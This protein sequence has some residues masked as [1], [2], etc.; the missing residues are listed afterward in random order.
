VTQ[1]S[2]HPPNCELASVAL[3]KAR[4]VHLRSYRA[5]TV[6]VARKTRHAIAKMAAVVAIFEGS[7]AISIVAVPRRALNASLTANEDDAAHCRDCCFDSLFVGS[8]A[9][10]TP[11]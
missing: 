9:Y 6:A 2:D 5:S 8:A 7:I 11:R 1:A 10:E 4:T 3:R